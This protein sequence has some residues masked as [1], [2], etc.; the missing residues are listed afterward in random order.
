MTAM[1]LSPTLSFL[2]GM[3]AAFLV[4]SACSQPPSFQGTEF[5]PAHQAPLFK[6]QDQ[7]GK[8][9]SSDEFAGKVVVLSFLYTAC[10]DVCPVVTETLRRTYEQLGDDTKHVQ[11][12]AISVDPEQDTVEQ[13]HR[14]SE[15]KGMLHK[16]AFLVG[17]EAELE[18]TWR[19]YYV[20]AGRIKQKR[21]S[22]A[23]ETLSKQEARQDEDTAYLIT[24][25]EAIYL[26]DGEG[27]L[28]ILFT[29]LSLDAGPLV[30]DIRLL[31]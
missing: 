14:Y 17:E 30:H 3:G 11:F 23:L 4:A 5:K 26:I 29:N 18:A 12:V 20:A 6:L 7:F 1:R 8:W 13:V 27:R 25:T 28:R 2:A 24:H 19:S 9:V 21:S 15:E 10:P 31:L 16:W 22:N